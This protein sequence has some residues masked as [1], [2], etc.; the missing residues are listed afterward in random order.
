MPNYSRACIVFADLVYDSQRFY[1]EEIKMRFYGRASGWADA[2]SAANCLRGI[3]NGLDYDEYIPETR[4][5]CSSANYNAKTFRMRDQ[6]LR[7]RGRQMRAC[8][9]IRTIMLV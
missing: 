5:H 6:E 1:A 9:L 4:I 3:V 2:C 7:N 8:V